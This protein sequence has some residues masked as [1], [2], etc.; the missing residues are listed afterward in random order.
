M[1][2][3]KIHAKRKALKYMPYERPDA[4]FPRRQASRSFERHS[5]EE[6][7]DEDQE[8]TEEA[9]IPVAIYYEEPVA[10]LRDVIAADGRFVESCLDS[11][12]D[13]FVVEVER[14]EDLVLSGIGSISQ[15]SYTTDIG[16][17]L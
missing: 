8:E 16:V 5:W 1:K 4:P 11:R 3:V 14:D 13:R 2:Y 15:N 12:C 6:E 7:E 9:P 10:V 17:E